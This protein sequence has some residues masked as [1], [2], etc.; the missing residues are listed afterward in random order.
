[1][2]MT[3][4]IDE[5]IIMVHALAVC[6]DLDHLFERAGETLNKREFEIRA[7]IAAGVSDEEIALKLY[8]S[9]Q[10]V[11]THLHE[12]QRKIEAP[13]RLQAAL[14]A[15]DYEFGCLKRI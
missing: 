8:I 14:W 15:E 1:M 13:N 11:K 4:V 6:K 7:L 3:S 5:K 2:A 9:T 10:V 12:I